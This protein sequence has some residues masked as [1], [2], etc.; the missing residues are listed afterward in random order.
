MG[1]V[2]L[3]GCAESGP[4]VLA[5]AASQSN[6]GENR[7]VADPG[8]PAPDLAAM[9]VGFQVEGSLPQMPATARSWSV[10]PYGEAMRETQRI[11][12]ALGMDVKAER[13][14]DD[15]YTFVAV[16]ETTNE[17]VTLWN[18]LGVGGWWTYTTAVADASTPC[19]PGAT[20][21]PGAGLPQSPT[22]LLSTQEALTRVGEFFGRSQ[23][24]SAD[25]AL[26][27]TATE[28]GTSVTG[29]L[30]A[31]GVA[32]NIS[33]NFLYGPGG[34]LE[35]ASGP[36]VSLRMADEYPLADV[37][38]SVGRLSLPRYSMPGSA[39]SVAIDAASV[40]SSTGSGGAA[41]VSIPITGVRMSLME[42]RLDNGS[43]MLL[44]AYTYTNIDGDVGTVI[45]VADE[46]LVFPDAPDAPGTTAPP[47][48]PMELDEES[49]SSLIGLTETEAG[50]VAAERGWVVR[51]AMRDGQAFMLTT[52]YRSDRVNLTVAD[53]V[54]T[55][56]TIG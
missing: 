29:Q 35:F 9:G 47:R 26:T 49:A 52:D 23:L 24:K 38:Q 20:P 46:H 55:S 33:I 12:D 18:H 6:S 56:V 1:A 41:P 36:M 54:V 2:S 42:S 15:K 4:V 17:T 30:L 27:A 32:S 19:A 10:G 22:N 31:G 21:C 3:S 44:P 5:L 39:V 37:Q 43:R 13:A 50:K 7:L 28:W 53:G 40:Q 34:V 51:T 48:E 14:S 45:A 16:D 11:A 25:Y 8:G